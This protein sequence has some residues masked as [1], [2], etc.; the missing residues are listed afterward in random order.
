MQISTNINA[1]N[2]IAGLLA[3]AGA[4]A[5]GS[6]ASSIWKGALGAALEQAVGSTAPL[7]ESAETAG[8]AGQPVA[9]SSSTFTAGAELDELLGQILTS[10]EDLLGGQKNAAPASAGDGTDAAALQGATDAKAQA[11]AD[12]AAAGTESQALSL[13]L[14][15]LQ[16]R[17][18]EGKLSL[19]LRQPNEDGEEASSKLEGKLRK[20][21]SPEAELI[22][23]LS[24]VLQLLQAAQAEQPAASKTNA[25]QS[26]KTAAVT[27]PTTESGEAEAM[28]STA[29]VPAE[30]EP[31]PA[32]SESKVVASASEAA[33]AT[34]KPEASLKSD[35]AGAVGQTMS[36]LK[37]QQ[38]VKAAAAESAEGQQAVAKAQPSAG[39]SA[40]QAANLSSAIAARVSEKQSIS[41]A[42]KL[43]LLEPQPK[44]DQDSDQAASVRLTTSTAGEAAKAGLGH[45]MSSDLL[46]GGMPSEFS[47][48]VE[49]SDGQVMQFRISH[50][51]PQ[52]LS[53]G[54]TTG[55]VRQEEAITA[56][57]QIELMPA[58]ADA[59]ALGRTALPAVNR[60]EA[61]LSL[62][63]QSQRPP[64]LELL[65]RPQTAA[66][67]A[68][69][70]QQETSSTVEQPVTT[71]Q[72]QIQQVVLAA[73]TLTTSAQIPAQ[74]PVVKVRAGQP[75][76]SEAETEA[77][78]P[79]EPV[80]TQAAELPQI[81]G[82]SSTMAQKAGESLQAAAGL[83][84]STAVRSG[85]L[86]GAAQ[87]I[88]RTKGS[89]QL[90][91]GGQPAAETA[92]PFSADLPLQLAQF[93]AIR[94]PEGTASQVVSAVTLARISELGS[95]ARKAGN[96][97]YRA[98]LRLDPP[99]LGRVD[100]NILVQGNSVAMQLSSNNGQ[101][102]RE[103]R[104]SAAALRQSLTEAGLSVADIEIVELAAQPAGTDT[105]GG[106][107][108]GEAQR[109]SAAQEHQQWQERHMAGALAGHYEWQG[110]L[111]SQ[112]NG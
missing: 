19:S 61:V 36:G 74:T 97:E 69:A 88:L 27:A 17:L 86:R 18:A 80:S 23:A 50:S 93:S 82:S 22:A 20:V 15:P 94:Q 7:A 33:A 65:A 54:L 11:Q 37:K 57:R 77:V 51:Q 91:R 47:V 73:G 49:S 44:A 1:A 103:L 76:D 4:E 63:P 32:N 98:T 13:D 34:D 85:L 26:A 84:R 21:L 41:A 48:R 102:R 25:E 62:L 30:A 40:Q 38:A 111:A 52:Q 2:Q 42:P 78:V 67:A 46:A 79:T 45:T 55:A 60:A 104:E 96:G 59:L 68:A 66:E 71:P 31:K 107:G 112:L 72:G 24:S 29:T 99:N 39:T 108:E 87:D 35:A 3:G 28:L 100:V 9:D 43:E 83:T 109:H 16:L 53:A 14:G 5:L 105:S 92:A 12:A 10:L 6:A 101:A 95:E 81:Q 90:E 89:Q 70:Q 58:P 106:R 75:Q 8:A 110:L 56:G 64:Q